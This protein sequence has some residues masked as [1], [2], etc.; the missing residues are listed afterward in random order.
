MRI[1]R[2]SVN[3]KMIPLHG[4]DGVMPYV[5]GDYAWSFLEVERFALARRQVVRIDVNGTAY[6]KASILDV[7]RYDAT[8]DTA[9]LWIRRRNLFRGDATIYCNRGTLDEL[10]AKCDGLEYWLFLADWTGSPHQPG[11]A[12]PRG[13]RLAAVQ[14]E[15]IPGAYDATA[16]YADDWH[17]KGRI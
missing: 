7:E 9:V 4:T 1:F 3:P 2:D 16:V 6:R 10:F 5:N 17:R 14:Y 8:P 15:T 12:L 11:L 13:V